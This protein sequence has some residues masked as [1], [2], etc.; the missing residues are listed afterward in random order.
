MRAFL[1]LPAASRVALVTCAL[2]LVSA[3]SAR[4]QDFGT[5]GIPPQHTQRQTQ[6]EPVAPRLLWV[7]PRATDKLS[8]ISATPACHLDALLDRAGE[9]AS[10]LLEH[11]ENF[12]AH[13]RVRFERIDNHGSSVIYMSGRFDY[14]ADF[15]DAASPLSLR[16]TRTA[17]GRAND[18]SLEGEVDHG[19][20]GMALVFH[21]ALRGD[22][23]MKCEGYVLR[24]GR[25]VF[26]VSF[27]QAAGGE[28]RAISLVTPSGS[29]AVPIRGRAWIA[30]RTGEV[31]HLETYLARPMLDLGVRTDATVIDYAPVKFQSKRVTLWLPQSAAVYANCGKYKTIIEHNFSDFQIFSV[32]SKQTIAPPQSQENPESHD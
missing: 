14:Q 4:A 3:P 10:A 2:A 24:R 18:A 25:G 7:P 12:D 20:A 22:F 13:E 16:E 19:L 26:V 17:I 21:P 11:L 29:V 15:G 28:A 32:E 30:E 27:A 6:A 9:R 5:P 31:V 1:S 23:E 8:D